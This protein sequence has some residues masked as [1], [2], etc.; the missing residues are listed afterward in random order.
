MV[1]GVSGGWGGGWVSEGKDLLGG[2]DVA[3]DAAARKKKKPQSMGRNP[4]PSHLAEASASL[5]GRVRGGWMPQFCH[6]FS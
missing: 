3:P 2:V 4:R 5:G 6:H 1:G